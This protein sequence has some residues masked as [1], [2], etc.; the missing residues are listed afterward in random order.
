MVSFDYY[1]R[2]HGDELW[3]MSGTGDLKGYVVPA[4]RG[5]YAAYTVVDG[6]EWLAGTHADKWAAFELLAQ[7]WAR[8]EGVEV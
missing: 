1:A 6:L 2:P 3:M 4:G 7:E 5:E 8:V